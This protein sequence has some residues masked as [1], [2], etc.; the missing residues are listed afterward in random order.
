MGNTFPR[1]IAFV[2]LVALAACGESWTSKKIEDPLNIVD[3]SELNDVMLATADPNAAVDHF[4]DSLSKSPDRIDLQRGLALSLV[5][6]KR[7]LEAVPIYETLVAH[8][9]AEPQDRINFADALMRGNDWKA[10][11]AQ[12][13]QVPPTIETYQ[14]YRLEAMIADSNKQ[15]TK[16]DSFYEIATGLTT[17]PAKVLNNWG[18]SKLTRGDQKAAEK[19]FVEA[20]THN[21]NLFISKNNLVLARAARGNFDL[22]VIP[23]TE[24]ERAQLL[25]TAGLSAA[26]QGQTAR[27]QGL[28]EEAIDAHPR[29]FPEAVRSLEGLGTAS[30]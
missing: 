5:R 10:A 1:A 8:P 15:W 17:R 24:I 29:H 6:A 4:R 20:I 9:E 30:G 13:N 26:K 23:M 21:P 16:A 25:H 7:H 14:R 2:S 27:A 28:F 18:F 22:P 19:L 3:A 11:E 12:L